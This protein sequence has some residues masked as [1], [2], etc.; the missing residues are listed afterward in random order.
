MKGIDNSILP[1][2]LFCQSTVGWIGFYSNIAGV[3][4]SVAVAL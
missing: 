4:V 3:I 2:V 1:D